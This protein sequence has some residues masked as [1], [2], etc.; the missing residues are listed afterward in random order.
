MYTYKAG[1]FCEAASISAK[2]SGPCPPGFV[3]PKGTSNPRPSP[4]GHFA[5]Y[6]GT[7][8]AA[9]CLPGFYSP[10]IQSAQCYPCPPGTSC[11]VEGLV[12][13]SICPPGTYRSVHEDDGVPCVACPQ[14]TWSKQWQCMLRALILGSVCVCMLKW[15]LLTCYFCLSSVVSPF[16]A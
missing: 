5:Q 11:E 14:G 13:A 7:V 9:A 3:C 12:S 16:A 6:F 15:L 2:G 8:E 10:T 1:F 4:K